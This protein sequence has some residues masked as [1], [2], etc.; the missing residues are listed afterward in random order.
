MRFILYFF[1]TYLIK[2][3]SQYIL[4]SPLEFCATFVSNALPRTPSM[5]KYAL[6]APL[7]P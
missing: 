7:V 6:D 3:A 4:S 2:S 1:K 5:V